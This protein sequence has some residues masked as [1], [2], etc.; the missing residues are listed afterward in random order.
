MTSIRMIFSKSILE[1]YFYLYEER[2]VDL[3]YDL[4]DL[5]DDLDEREDLDEEYLLRLGD[6]E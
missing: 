6:R 5:E 4:D 2:E 1:V 3:E